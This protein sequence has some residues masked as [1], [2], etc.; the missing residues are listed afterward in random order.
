MPRHMHNTHRH[1]D[2]QS[3]YPM[4]KKCHG[5]VHE[6]EDRDILFPFLEFWII[7]IRM[8]WKN[9]AWCLHSISAW[10]KWDIP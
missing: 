3:L 2:K 6:I 1:R 7:Q 10:F 4:L 9:V 8:R 5:Y